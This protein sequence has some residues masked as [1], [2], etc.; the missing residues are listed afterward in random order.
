M[1]V[2]TSTLTSTKD[3]SGISPHSRIHLYLEL[4]SEVPVLTS[5]LTP[6]RNHH[7]YNTYFEH[8][9]NNWTPKYLLD[10]L[11]LSIMT[12]TIYPVDILT[13]LS[14]NKVLLVIISCTC[15]FFLCLSSFGSDRYNS[16][17]WLYSTKKT[18][19]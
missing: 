8:P 2:F 18:R 13:Y 4:Q 1:P 11:C 14:C 12:D 10:N 6:N 5:T 3:S 15:S 9:V 19:Q 17:N 7:I 16:D